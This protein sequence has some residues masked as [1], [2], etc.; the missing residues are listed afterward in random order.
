MGKPYLSPYH[1]IEFSPRQFERL[2]SSCF[3]HREMLGQ[4][5]EHSFAE[6]PPR[7]FGLRRILKPVS[8]II[9]YL[10]GT[11]PNVR[12]FDLIPWSVER[13]WFVPKYMTS[14]CKKS[15]KSTARWE[16]HPN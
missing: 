5:F 6:L 8:L 7:G 4:Y 12:K 10:D 16:I 1:K 3:L 13:W 11:K 2:L 14:I 15:E 9:G